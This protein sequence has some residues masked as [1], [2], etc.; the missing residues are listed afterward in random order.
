[1]GKYSLRC[2]TLPYVTRTAQ[3]LEK[4]SVFY[5][6]VY[7]ALILS[8]ETNIDDYGKVSRKKMFKY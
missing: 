4:D 8:F 7:N 3:N 1:M 2:L 6:Q 5:D